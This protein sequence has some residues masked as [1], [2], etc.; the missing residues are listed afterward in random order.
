MRVFCLI[1]LLIGIVSLQGNTSFLTTMKYLFYSW[2]REQEVRLPED[3]S[4]PLS[5]SSPNNS[6]AMQYCIEIV[7]WARLELVDSKLL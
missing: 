5:Q 3:V 1:R 7:L 2:L 6:N 4:Q